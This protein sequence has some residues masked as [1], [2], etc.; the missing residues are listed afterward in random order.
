MIAETKKKVVQL[1]EI[2]RALA[3][4]LDLSH[5]KT[6]RLARERDALREEVEQ[7]RGEVRA[8]RA[9]SAQTADPLRDELE[10]ALR[11]V[12]ALRFRLEDAEQLRVESTARA[13][14]A[15]EQLDLVLSDL[16]R[17]EQERAVLRLQLEESEGSLEQ[18][19]VHLLDLRSPALA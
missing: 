1:V 11:L 13:A 12:E 5:R 9:A 4:D 2:N 8:H 17:A 7:L 19:R 18:I 6:A 15:E 14:Q 3:Y 16:S 10:Q